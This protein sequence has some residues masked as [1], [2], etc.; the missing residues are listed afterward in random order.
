MAIS[1]IL[2]VDAT[3]TITASSAYTSGNALG[4]KLTFTNLCDG[5]QSFLYMIRITDLANQ[6]AATDIL[7]FDQSFTATADKN[8]IAVSAADCANLIGVVSLVAGDWVTVQAGRAVAT[9]IIAYPMPLISAVDNSIYAQL[10][11]RGTPTY[12]TTA[13]ISVRLYAAPTRGDW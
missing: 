1:K 3:P 9:K 11:T 10:V 12:G 4:G 8:A 13:D 5:G 6:K 7:L 2:K